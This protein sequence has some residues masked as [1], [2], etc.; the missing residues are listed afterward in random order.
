MLPSLLILHHEPNEPASS[1]SRVDASLAELRHWIDCLSEDQ[2]REEPVLRLRQALA[3]LE[4]KDSRDSR[5]QL[6]GLLKSWCIKQKESST[7]K[8]TF[9][10]VRQCMVTAVIAEGNRLRALEH[11]SVQTSFRSLFRSS[12]EQPVA[13]LVGRS[14]SRPRHSEGQSKDNDSHKGKYT[15]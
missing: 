4:L 6:Q 2:Q 3:V 15:K 9:S 7:R 1:V 14:R 10:Q 8:K 11:I 12:A 5:M 13:P